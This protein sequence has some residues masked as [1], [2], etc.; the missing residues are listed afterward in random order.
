MQEK[1]RIRSTQWLQIQAAAFQAVFAD[2][3]AGAQCSDS[4]E[5]HG[6]SEVTRCHTSQHCPKYQAR[7]AFALELNF[8]HCYLETFTVGG[9]FATSPGTPV[10]GCDPQC[11]SGGVSGPV[12]SMYSKSAGLEVQRNSHS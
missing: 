8:G 5:N 11:V 1:H 3:T 2:T 10:W 4:A 6:D 9:I 12:I 7:S